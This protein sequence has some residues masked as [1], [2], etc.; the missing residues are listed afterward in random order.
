MR[1]SPPA[2]SEERLDRRRG[3]ERE[4]RSLHRHPLSPHRPIPIPLLR[5]RGD[6]RPRCPRG[7]AIL[8]LP[9]ALRL[10]QGGTTATPG[11]GEM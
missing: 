8:P 1:G 9:G 10:R 11:H 6:A 4:R 3:A 5:H 7:A 2:R